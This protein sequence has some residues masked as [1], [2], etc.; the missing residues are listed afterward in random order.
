MFQRAP[1][2]R[3]FRRDTSISMVWERS[4][5]ITV[6]YLYGYSS[7]IDTTITSILVTVTLQ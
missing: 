6:L 1:C 7:G 5:A 4:D 2:R 3:G